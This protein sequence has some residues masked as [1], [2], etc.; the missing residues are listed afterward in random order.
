MGFMRAKTQAEAEIAPIDTLAD[1]AKLVGPMIRGHRPIR[2]R[3]EMPSRTHFQFMYLVRKRLRSILASRSS[4]FSLDTF[5]MPYPIKGPHSY[6]MGRHVLSQRPECA[7]GIAM[8]ASEWATLERALA[9][10]IGT[11]LFAYMRTEFESEMLLRLTLNN[12]DSLN[13]RL[14]LIDRVLNIYVSPR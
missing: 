3:S 9:E 4:S 7:I 1:G 8:V 12:I 2:P 6:T 11:A 10:G 14:D 5:V 13:A